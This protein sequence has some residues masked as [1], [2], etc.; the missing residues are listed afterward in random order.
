M[1]VTRRNMENAVADL[2]KKLQHAS[3]VID[4]GV[5]L[6]YWIFFQYI[7]FL[8]RHAHLYEQHVFEHDYII[9]SHI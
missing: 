4:V 3:D 5:H 9:N 2:T 1:Y 6:L 8:V 7:K